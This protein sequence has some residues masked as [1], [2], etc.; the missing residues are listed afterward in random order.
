MKL[1]LG[2][3]LDIFFKMRNSIYKK[4]E[5]VWYIKRSDDFYIGP[6][7]KKPG[8]TKHLYPTCERVRFKLINDE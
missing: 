2:I 5:Y 6:Y 1:Y 3:L 4:P 7:H 8:K